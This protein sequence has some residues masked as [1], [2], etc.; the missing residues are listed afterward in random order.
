MIR[1]IHTEI[2]KAVSFKNLKITS[3]AFAEGDLIPPKYTCDGANINPPLEIGLLPES[4]KSLAII[5]TGTY[6]ESREW[7]HWLAWNI[8][9][10]GHLDENRRM[11]IEG[12]NYFGRKRYEGPCPTGGLHKYEFRVYA[13]NDVLHLHSSSTKEDLEKAMCDHI[14]GFGVMSCFYQRHSPNPVE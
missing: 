13:L 3:A 10:V 12:L 4:T 9:A 5:V 2:E 11:E 7:A 8:P 6:D 14:I 1:N